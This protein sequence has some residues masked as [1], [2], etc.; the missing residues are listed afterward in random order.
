METTG[1]FLAL[2]QDFRTGEVIVQFAC[3][4]TALAQIDDIK[5]LD[6]LVITAK[7]YREKRSLDANATLWYCLDKIAAALGT[8]KW[9][10][11][12]Q[13]LRRYGKFT[14]VIVK[15]Q[16]VEAMKRQWRECEIVGDITV[17]GQNAV[18][19]LCY[20]GS[21]TYNT[22]EFSRLLDGAI[23]EMKEMGLDTPLPEDVRAALERW[24]SN[25]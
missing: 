24:E 9:N 21:S 6:K 17:N 3:D 22:Q 1:R 18:Q 2:M 25:G 12:L 10:V 19:M 5:D 7:K 15:Q 8:D 13:M 4:R 23:S 11:Y 20:F 16:A 14:H